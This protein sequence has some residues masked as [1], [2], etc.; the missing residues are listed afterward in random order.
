[1]R[2]LPLL[3]LLVVLPH[4]A[5]ARAA[6]PSPQ[7]VE[8]FEKHV[9]PVLAGKCFSCH[10]P[11]KQ[12]AGLRLD[13]PNGVL[14]GGDN[15][16]AVVPG[17]PDQSL[18]IRAVR[19]DGELKMPPKSRLSPGEVE[20]LTAWVRQGAAWPA[21]SPAVVAGGAEEV[22]R[23]WA[24]R[25]V[26][27]PAV[28]AVRSACWVRTPVDAFVLAGLE[29]RGLAPAAQADRRTLLRRLSFDLLG[30]PPT[31]E[32]VQ[33][34][35][36][37]TSPQAYEKL[38]DR[39]LASPHYGERW[40]R[41]W[42]DVARYADTRGYVFTEERKF[43]YSYTYRDWVI[44]A[45]NEDLPYDQF[46]VQQLA[47][48]RLPL[49]EDKGPLAAMGFLTLG[50]RFLNNQHDV[51]DDRIDVTT[52]GLLGLTVAC[53]RCHDHKFDPIPARD[54]Y[55]LYGVFA[56]SVEPRDPPLLTSART[57][58]ETLAFE[59]ELKK[60]TD[61]VEKYRAAHKAELTTGNAK[62]RQ[63]LADLRNK[64]NQWRVSGPGSPPR[65]MV[66]EDAPVATNPYVF[67]RGNPAN[68]GPSVPR[69]NT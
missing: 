32:Q 17:K 7:A 24:F 35:E 22:R 18:L 49:G 12:R 33:A 45:F 19:R 26:R 47:A 55:S 15:G 60:R 3:G 21:A 50:R 8:F 69:R 54:Y 43:P 31:P 9:R 42:L 61:E 1:M 52:R 10:G 4:S 66:L 27:K 56:S 57:T 16:P 64:V 28:P 58:P 40:G 34:F 30:L 13:I 39:L 23:H 68:H 11:Q 20:N 63:E 46:V 67:L 48:D 51:I 44:R 6:E 25:P 38:V 41:H 62:A 29:A 53:A 2:S 14:K 36:A 65:A 5:P 59:A 37:D